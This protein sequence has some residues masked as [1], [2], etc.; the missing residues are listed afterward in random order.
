[1]AALRLLCHLTAAWIA[2]AAAAVPA[3][4]Q[5]EFAGDRPAWL[6][7]PQA[8]ATS[9]PLS[10]EEL[11]RQ[12][13]AQN[14]QLQQ[15]VLEV[16]AAQGRA[17]QA[18]LYPNPIVSL[19]ADELG[20]R[21]GK[22][23]ILTLPQ[24]TQEIVTGGKLVLSR[25]VAQ[26]EV[27]LATLAVVRQRYALLTAI[28]QGYFE[29]LAAQRRVELLTEMTRLATA[30]YEKAAALLKGKQIAELDWLVFRIE[31]ERIGAELDAAQQ[32]RR[33]ALGRLSA[34]LGGGQELPDKPLEGSLETPLPAY[35]YEQAAARILE[36]H[37]DVR[38]AQV[39][40]GRAQ[41]T[42][43]RAQVEPIPNVTVGAGYVRQNQN[44]SNDWMVQVSLPVPVLNR[45]QGNIA[46]AQAELGRANLERDRVRNDLTNR[47]WT[48]LGSYAAA[49]QRIARYRPRILEDAQRS[50]QLTLQR[51]AQSREIA[52]VLLVLQAQRTVQ[53]A[54]LEYLRALADAWR[55]S[56]ELAGLLQEEHWP[57]H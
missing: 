24:I 9:V 33:A 44:K 52:D 26:R 29:V 36:T 18:G 14:P 50:Y 32:E 3:A 22:A 10:L 34:T 46:A 16:D 15:A 39:G 11:V 5:S 23:G 53:E 1:M 51:I 2:A 48:A 43:Q 4:A 21:Q 31:L 40:I 54:N 38:A 7:S 41:L 17:Y 12:G 30:A 37:P 20:D 8:G 35:T 6:G 45:N 55:A 56:S 19:I 42:L 27:D 13:L 25:A 49:R 57:P 47:L 28:R